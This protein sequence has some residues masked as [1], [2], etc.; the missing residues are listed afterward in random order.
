LKPQKVEING[1]LQWRWIAVG[2]EDSCFSNGEEIEVYDYSNEIK[3]LIIHT[4]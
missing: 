2:F 4:E 1:K 3:G